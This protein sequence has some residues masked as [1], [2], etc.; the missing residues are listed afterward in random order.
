[1]P[2]N[3]NK[4]YIRKIDKQSLNKQMS[5][6]HEVHDEF[7]DSLPDQTVITCEGKTS[8]I[9]TNVIIQLA[10]DPRFSTSM[11]TALSTEGTPQVDDLMLM[12]KVKQTEYI[13][14]LVKPT[15]PIYSFCF[16]LIRQAEKHALV[17]AED[18]DANLNK[19]TGGYNKYYYGAPGC[20]K[21]YYIQEMLD[22]KEIIDDNRFRVTFHPDYSNSDFVGQILP[23]I[24]SVLNDSGEKIGEKVKYIFN[25][26]PFTK[27]LLRSYQTNDMVYLII[28][29]LN[30]GNASAIFGDLFQL[31]DRVDDVEDKRFSES[32]YPITNVNVHK[33]I[34]DQLEEKGI[35]YRNHDI[36]I[37]S[38]LTILA[39]MNTSDQNVFTLDTA[40]KRRWLSEGISNSFDKGKKHE[41]KDWRV[42]GTNITWERFLIKLNNKILDYKI[43]N[44]TSED[45]RLGKY[46]V[47]KSC[48]TK[49]PKVI[50][51]CKEEADN[52]AYKVLEYIWNDVCK[53]GQ[54]DWF[55]TKKYR[56]LEEL[57]EGFQTEQ[58]AVFET[59]DFNAED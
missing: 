29:E 37:P 46:F 16:D 52:F 5:F 30:R 49:E 11:K 25:P 45:K 57:L 59:I 12:F 9:K 36:I 40:F 23:T 17:L 55:N 39:T 35:E 53:Y 56:T 10:T 3:S 42:P 47:N 21:S 26:G 20:G 58:L 34:K 7:L 43:E 2:T 15:D 24:E 51:E 4:V 27:A 14:Q 8:H 18:L 32:R 44:S 6:T 1:M 38:N 28:E 31:L 48:L 22:E 13:V 19:V 54:S 33:Y 41:Y 50:A